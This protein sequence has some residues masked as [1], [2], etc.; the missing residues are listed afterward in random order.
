MI[1]IHC[2]I[3]PD[4]DDGP[5]TMEESLEMCRIAVAD[6]ITTIVAT[7]HHNSPYVESLPADVVL[8]KVAELRE[9]LHRHTIPLE[10]L[11]GQEIH[12]TETI[13]ED[14]L[15]GR[16]LTL[17]NAGKYALIEMPA[18]SVPFYVRQ[19]VE[20][21]KVNGITAIIAHPERNRQVQQ[22]P[23]SLADLIAA[24]ALGQITA[25]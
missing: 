19:V 8:K 22:D 17:N 10:I 13:V 21:L 20:R 15:Q 12:I 9:E 1:D 18:D 16:S 24:G 25:G 11:P 4:I 14:I 6:G 5:R 3:L 23:Q 7:P 2:H